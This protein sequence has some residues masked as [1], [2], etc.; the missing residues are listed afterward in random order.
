MTVNDASRHPREIAIFYHRQL[1]NQG[2][3]IGA[4]VLTLRVPLVRQALSSQPADLQ[5]RRQQPQAR[6]KTSSQ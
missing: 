2:I 3:L 5:P 4:A 1:S 6:Y